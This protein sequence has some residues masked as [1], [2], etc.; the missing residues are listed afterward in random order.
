MSDEISGAVAKMAAVASGAGGLA[1]IA[2]ALHGGERRVVVLAIEGFLGAMLGIMAAGGVLYWDAALRDA[3][4]GLI[5][6]GA[7]S[8]FAGVMGTRLLDLVMEILRR[9][10][11][12]PEPPK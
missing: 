1:R 7:V 10:A 12:P 6:V 3:G 5:M 11:L 4:W 2:L 9:R 8:G